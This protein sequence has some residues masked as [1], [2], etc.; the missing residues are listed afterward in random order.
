MN[1]SDKMNAIDVGTVRQQTRHES[2]GNAVFT[3]PDHDVAR[4][5]AKRTIGQRAARR[6]VR[7]NIHCNGGLAGARSPGDQVKLADCQP[8]LPKPV[9]RLRLDL[10]GANKIEMRPLVVA[11]AFRAG[12]GRGG[13]LCLAD[14][15]LR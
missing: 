12:R 10:V 15:V 3:R 9:D 2:V 7:G 1:A 6:N 11:D 8:V 13:S 14:L 4:V 5:P